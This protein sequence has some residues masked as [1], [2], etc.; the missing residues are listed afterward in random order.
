MAAP[1]IRWNDEI[2]EQVMTVYFSLFQQFQQRMQGLA[3]AS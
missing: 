1:A 3:D 2:T